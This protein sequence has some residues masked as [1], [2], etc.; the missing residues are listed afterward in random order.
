MKPPDGDRPDRMSRPAWWAIVLVS[1]LI[2][3]LVA[4]PLWKPLLVAGALA[5]M[6]DPWHERVARAFHNR[7]S[8]SAVLLTVGIVVLI[9]GP[10]TVVMTLAIQQAIEVVG[11]VR[12]TLAASGLE[13]LID[14]LPSPL[15]AWTG[16]VRD[17]LPQELDEL[18]GQVAKGGRWALGTLPSTLGTL[19]HLAVAVVMFFL[20]LFF[21]LRD[22]RRLVAWAVRTLPLAPSA[23]L[24]I[25]S[26]LKAVSRSVIG[27]NFVT[28]LVQAV[29][30]TAAY[31]IVGVPSPIFFGL[32]TLFASFIPS[33]GTALATLPVAG[34]MLVLHHT[35]AAIFI[36]LWSLIV[37]GGIDNF[38]R[39]ILIRGGATHI[40]TAAFLFAIVGAIAAVGGV[41]LFLGPLA[42]V[43]V[44]TTVRLARQAQDQ[45][46][47]SPDDESR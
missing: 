41:G 8:L 1:L 2:A 30:A 37:V 40:H 16:Q 31:L 34:L 26:D 4:A 35:G 46:Q 20:A 19:L 43:F 23:T 12:R 44:T 11:V 38:L 25:L 18:H 45:A 22:G 10:I 17:A 9:S 7:R 28:G 14:K 13:G 32:L 36:A 21:F 15:D 47:Q 3:G 29:V 24:R 33:I 27:A 6:L 42:L 5:A 39:P